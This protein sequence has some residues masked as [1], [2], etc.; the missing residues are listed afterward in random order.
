MTVERIEVINAR[1]ESYPDVLRRTGLFGVLPNDTDEQAVSKLNAV[2]AESAA[3]AEEFS[4]PAYATVSAG[5]AATTAG[6][7]FR[8]PISGTTPVEYDRYQRTPGGSVLAAPLATTVALAATTGAGLSGFSQSVAYAAGV[9]KKLR[10]TLSVTDA[11][12]NADPTGAA[13]CA[14]AFSA[15][16]ADA[17][18]RG[19]DVDLTP[20]RFNFL[21]APTIPAGSICIRGRGP[22]LTTL[23]IAHGGT[24]MQFAPANATQFVEVSGFSLEAAHTAPC[25]LGFDVAFPEVSSYP[26]TQFRAHNIRFVS[27]LNNTSSPYAQTWGRGFKLENVWNSKIF[28]VSGSSAPIPGDTGNTGFLEVTGGDLALIAPVITDVHWYYGADVIRASAY[29][30]GVDISNC[31]FVGLTRG[32]YV[33]STTPVGGAD[34]TYRSQ[35]VWLRST[36]IAAHTACIDFDNVFDYYQD[37]CNLQR[38]AHSSATNWIGLKLNN[39]QRP[40]IIGGTFAGNEGDV[41]ITT[42]GIVATG[43]N[44]AHGIV[45]GVVFENCDTQFSLDGSTAGWVIS[46][47]R[48]TGATADVYVLDGVHHKL[49]WQRTDGVILYASD[50]MSGPI[51]GGAYTPTL[52]GIT[53]VAAATAYE[54]Q[55]SR[56]GN[57]ITVSGRFDLDP[58]TTSV[59]TTMDITLPVSSTL[60][61]PQ[62]CCGTA[63]NALGGAGLIVGNTANNKAQFQVTPPTASNHG[64]SFILM[65]R[66]A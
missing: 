36:H 5:E 11:P 44:S 59:A 40:N 66:V 46:D 64:Y 12:Y 63:S 18:A 65:Y 19:Y 52:T 37:D 48:S 4:G 31:E 54:C 24:A 53:N 58:T 55:Y 42:A 20:G 28:D 35:S 56:V 50:Q 43:S 22:S 38:W 47:N 16:Y 45:T 1:G 49:E 25:P 30:E 6:Q 15:C 51:M 9:G 61:L 27:N 17:I 60:A 21:S 32:I 29:M 14:A 39:V 2:A 26:L 57:M 8:V 34:N 7:F 3:F 62:Y 13:D 33:P 10:Q 41:G 23:V